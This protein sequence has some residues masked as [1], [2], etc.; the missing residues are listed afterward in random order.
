MSGSCSASL[1]SKATEHDFNPTVYHYVKKASIARSMTH[2]ATA[3]ALCGD[4]SVY[5]HPIAGKS[6]DATKGRVIC[7]LCKMVYDS[8]PQKKVTPNG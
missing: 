8:L 7:P 4:R 1:K 6:V 2:G 5:S 3:K